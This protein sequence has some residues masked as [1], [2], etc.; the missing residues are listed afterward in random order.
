MHTVLLKSA[1]LFIL[2]LSLTFF[3]GVA[4]AYVALSGTPSADLCC[5]D[6]ADDPVPRDTGKCADPECRC[7]LCSSAILTLYT[8]FPTFFQEQPSPL[9]TPPARLQSGYILSIDYPP[10]TV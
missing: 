7:L 8:F 6:K 10:E 1:A 9:F 2:F 4:P 5:G 3:S